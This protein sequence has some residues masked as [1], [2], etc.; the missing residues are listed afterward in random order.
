MI[1]VKESLIY[2]C[3]IL[4]TTYGIQSSPEIFRK[5]KKNDYSVHQDMK[6]LLFH[7]LLKKYELELHI[8]VSEFL[9]TCNKVAQAEKLLNNFTAICVSLMYP[10][11]NLKLQGKIHVLFDGPRRILMILLWVLMSRPSFFE[12]MDVQLKQ[13]IID[14]SEK[15]DVDQIDDEEEEYDPEDAIQQKLKGNNVFQNNSKNKRELYEGLQGLGELRLV[16]EKKV[17]KV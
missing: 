11:F 16:L 17:F 12:Q 4:E 8:P 13:D 2:L 15:D 10:T 7:I 6:N 3:N 5:A 1:Q 9:A 14:M